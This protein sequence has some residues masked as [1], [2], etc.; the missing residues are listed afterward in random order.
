[1]QRDTGIQLLEATMP[2]SPSPVMVHLKDGEFVSARAAWLSVLRGRVWVT[3]AGDPDDHFLDSG[4]AMRLPPGRGALIGAEGDA[5][6]ML[7]AAPS[8][9]KGLRRFA[10]Q[11]L[12][13]LA[14]RR[15]AAQ[16]Q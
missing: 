3:H 11:C 2:E 12:A 5:Q 14:P 9:R 6:L 10:R 4:H 15:W 7:A 16:R 13:A 8:W 1:M